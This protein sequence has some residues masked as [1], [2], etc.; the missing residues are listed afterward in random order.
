MVASLFLV[1]IVDFN[2]SPVATSIMIFLRLSSLFRFYFFKVFKEAKQLHP[3][4]RV[5]ENPADVSGKSATSQRRIP[6][7]ALLFYA[8]RSYDFAVHL[9]SFTFIMAPLITD[10]IR[11]LPT[12]LHFSVS[13]R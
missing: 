13:I 11:A 4:P 8:T 12:T 6:L 2:F 3:V 5:V 1:R 7:S 9:T 10:Q